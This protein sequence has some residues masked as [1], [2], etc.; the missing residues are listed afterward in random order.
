V[1]SAD[2]LFRPRY[3]DEK[4]YPSYKSLLTER[5]SL[6]RGILASVFETFD[7]PD[8]NFVEQFQTTGFDTRY[9]ELYLH[10]YLSRSGF[11]LSRPRP[12]PDFIASRAGVSVAIEATTLNPSTSGVLASAGKSIADLDEEGLRE[13]I[14]NELPIRFG[15]ALSSKLQKRYWEQPDCQG[16]PFVIA[17]EPFHDEEALFLTDAALGTYVYG[18]QQTGEFT[19]RGVRVQLRRSKT[20]QEAAGRPVGV[21]YGVTPE[22]CPVQA[23]ERWLA[24]VRTVVPRYDRGPL[25]LR[26]DA[27]GRVRL[28]RLSDRGVARVVQ[29]WA[30]RAGL[31]PSRFAGHS[32]RAGLATSHSLGSRG[33]RNHLIEQASFDLEIRTIDHASAPCAVGVS[34]ATSRSWADAPSPVANADQKTLAELDGLCQALAKVAL[35]IL[36]E[37]PAGSLSYHAHFR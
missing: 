6:T 28:G 15:S 3:P 2:D 14:A 9:F 35:Q 16:K 10:A 11:E 31:D 22:T 12:S 36:G 20:D 1:A 33:S 21:P 17:V 5:A 7:D 24:H 30:E 26:L 29:R 34:D 19:Q 27:A 8:G 13:Y 25:F 37:P 32:L 23:L 4:L 18:I